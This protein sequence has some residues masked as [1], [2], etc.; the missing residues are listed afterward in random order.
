[1]YWL[2]CFTVVTECLGK[3]T[4]GRGRRREKEGRQVGRKEGGREGAFWLTVLRVQSILAEGHTGRSRGSRSYRS[5]S[6][7]VDERTRSIL[8]S[9]LI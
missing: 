4:E 1:M 2:P 8:A 3:A 9:L 6:R 7:G 5:S